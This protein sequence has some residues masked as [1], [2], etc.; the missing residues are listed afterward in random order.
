M[1]MIVDWFGFFRSGENC[2][3]D[4]WEVILFNLVFF[5]LF[6][7]GGYLNC[8]ELIFRRMINKMDFFFL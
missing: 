4:D 8:N 7:L 2:R 3:E 6:E 1:R 5:E